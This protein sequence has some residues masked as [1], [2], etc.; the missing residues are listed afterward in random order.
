M[1]L[2]LQNEGNLMVCE[3]ARQNFRYWQSNTTNA[4]TKPYRL[5]MQKDRNLVLYDSKGHAVWASNTY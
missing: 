2:V 5:M 4:G 1:G 3:I